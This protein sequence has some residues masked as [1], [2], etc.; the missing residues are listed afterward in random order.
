MP[1]E[2]SS[3]INSFQTTERFWNNS[4]QK[5]EQL[6]YIKDL[7]L[8]LDPLPMERV[9]GV[10]WCA[11]RDSFKFKINLKDKPVS[12]RGILSIVSSVYDPLGL[13]APLLLRRK[14]I[15]Q[16]LCKQGIDWDDPVPEM[17]KDLWE[18]WKEELHLLEEMEVR[19][20]FKPEGFVLIHSSSRCQQQNPLL[21][22]R[23]QG[24]SSSIEASYCSPAGAHSRVGVCTGK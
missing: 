23:R 5:I 15:L 9:L 13:A 8:D 18:T 1:K 19:R 12:R 2:A 24:P 22:G 20:F 4:L 6:A 7:D 14:R 3:C 17:L 11:E 10:E 16:H 21:S